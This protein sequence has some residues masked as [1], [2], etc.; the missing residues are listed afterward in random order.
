VTNFTIFNFG[1]IET[2]QQEGNHLKHRAVL[3]DLDGTLL[4]TLEDVAGAVNQ[5][6]SNLTKVT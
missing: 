3:F 2:Q 4:N 6:S 5:L 1:R